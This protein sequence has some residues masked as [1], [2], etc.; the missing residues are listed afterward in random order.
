M[1][2]VSQFNINNLMYEEI[3]M[4]KQKASNANKKWA[5]Q[6][7]YLTTKIICYFKRTVKN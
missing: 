7:G 3:D 5:F 2:F 4:L 1:K 6:R